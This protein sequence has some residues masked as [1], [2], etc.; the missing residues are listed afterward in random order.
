MSCILVTRYSHEP[1]PG[2]ITLNGIVYD[3]WLN[4]ETGDHRKWNGGAWEP[5]IEIQTIIQEVATRYGL[6]VGV[7]CSRSRKRFLV[8]VRSRAIRRCRAETPATLKQIGCALGHRHHSTIL[9]A[10]QRANEFDAR[11]K[12]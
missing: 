11:D 10:L 4:I 12:E 8:E 9:H 2:P 5:K 1:P 3:E 7:L 6:A